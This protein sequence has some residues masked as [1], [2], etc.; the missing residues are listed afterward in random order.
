[1]RTFCRASLIVCALLVTSLSAAI[2]G[3]VDIGHFTPDRVFRDFGGPDYENIWSQLNDPANFGPGGIVPHSVA[4]APAIPVATTEALAGLDIFVMSEVY[5]PMS[6]DEANAIAQFVRNGGCLVII[7][8]T[9]HATNP[10]GGNGTVPGNMV[11]SLLDGTTIL[12]YD[13]S[14]P[15]TATAGTISGLMAGITDGPFGTLGLGDSF[16]ASWHTPLSPGSAAAAIGA[17]NGS[18]VLAAIDAGALG[19]GAGAVLIAGDVLFSDAFVPPGDNGGVV[20]SEANATLFLNFVAKHASM[21][22]NVPE[23][24]SVVL[25]TMA[26]VALLPA[27]RRRRSGR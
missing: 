19:E 9:L 23:P 11:L 3:T 4:L 21:L 5:M 18:T 8:D 6:A 2:A 14:G 7:S 22:P 13:L 12:P 24:S 16:A 1:M 10:P 25:L 17:R 26:S 27:M 15:Q 20:E